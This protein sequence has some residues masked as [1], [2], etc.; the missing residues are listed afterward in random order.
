MEYIFDNALY[1]AARESR[2]R[3]LFR[4]VDAGALACKRILE[5]GCGTGELGQAFVEAGC[6]VVSIDARS[7]YIQE[8]R[9]RFPGRLAYVMDLEHWN[10]PALGRFHV[11]VCFGLL[12]HLATPREFLAACALAAP[13]LFLETAVT[14]SDEVVCPIIAEEG[15]DQ[16]C[17]GK[18]CRP[19]P[20]W[21]MQSLSSL[22]YEVQDIS[23]AEAN[24]G[25]TVPSVFDWKP[26]DDGQWQRDGAMLRKM[27]ICTRRSGS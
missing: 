20:A 6:E 4:H 5:L 24:W 18:G 11:V 8:L 2:L 19:S 27:L 7:E 1:H 14:D 3:N 13:Q 17:S 25:G 26:L 22:G 23:T 15:A 12:Y 16:A 10:P 21:L 9:S